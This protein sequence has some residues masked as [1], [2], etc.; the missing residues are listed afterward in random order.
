MSR[1]RLSAHK[2]N[3]ETG[4]YNSKNAYV[5]ACDRLCTNC[6]LKEC[7][8][9]VHFLI[10]CPAYEDLRVGLFQF[11]STSNSHFPNYD[12]GQKLMWLM[13]NDNMSCLHEV[14][15]FINDSMLR[16]DRNSS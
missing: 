15:K 7:E 4:R 10:K 6:D 16:R 3:V 8:D 12:T 1:F 5:P 9:E 14:A 11:V 2:L 13:S